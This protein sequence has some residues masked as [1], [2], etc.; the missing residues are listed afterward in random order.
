MHAQ[1]TKQA[2]KISRALEA[3]GVLIFYSRAMRL[4]LRALNLYSQ[5][6]WLAHYYLPP[7]TCH[8]SLGQ[9]SHQITMICTF[10][11]IN[12]ALDQNLT[13]FFCFNTTRRRQ[14][15]PKTKKRIEQCLQADDI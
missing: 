4:I 1:N 9:R 11:A 3:I 7:A 15:R 10:D 8:R 13:P 2:W 14:W 6:R 5:H 12:L